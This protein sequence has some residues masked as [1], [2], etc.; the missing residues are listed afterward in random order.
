MMQKFTPS[1]RPFLAVLPA[2]A[3]LLG[4]N[5][6][7]S[8]GDSA[9]KD[10]REVQLNGHTFTL[11]AGFEID[12][13]ASSPLVD[14]PITAAFDDEGRLYVTDSSG[15][16]DKVD[17]QL[18]EKPHRVVRLEDTDGDGRFDKSTVFAD[19]IGRASCRERV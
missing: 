1:M 18:A 16:N 19:K 9:P 2:L 7:V 10:I 5:G 11:P 17:K 15:S 14:R 6:F 4:T 8:S 13:V 3:L 12:L